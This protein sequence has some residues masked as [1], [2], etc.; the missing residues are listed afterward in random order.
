MSRWGGNRIIQTTWRGQL[1]SEFQETLESKGIMG[2][3]PVCVF[4]KFGGS[5]CEDLLR[6]GGLTVFL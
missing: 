3:G 1:K 4:C 6:F 5:I 2:N